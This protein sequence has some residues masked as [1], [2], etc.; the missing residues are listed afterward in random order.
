[1]V[2]G[3]SRP[4]YFLLS[5]HGL[6]ILDIKFSSFAPKTDSVLLGGLVHAISTFSDTI[7]DNISSESGTLNVIEREGKK[8][9][10]E[11]GQEVEAILVADQESMILMEKIRTILDIFE[12]NYLETLRKTHHI[13]HEDYL[14]FMNLTQKYLLA[15]LDENVVFRSAEKPPTFNLK[16]RIPQKWG[17]LYEFLDGKKSV[18]DVY[19]E[20]RWPKPYVLCRT[21][22]FQQLGIIKPVDISI[23]DTDLFI[24]DEAYLSGILLEQGTAYQS[25][26]KMWDE[27][28]VR[29]TQSLDGRNTIS[30]LAAKFGDTLEHERKVPHFLRWLSLQGYISPL[31]DSDLTIIIFEGFLNNLHRK[32]SAAVGDTVCYDM[33]EE[34]FRQDAS[35]ARRKGRTLSV[36]KLV[37]HDAVSFHFEKLKSIMKSRSEIITPLFQQAFLSFLDNI[38]RIISKVLGKK[39]ALQLIQLSILDTEKKYGPL[40]YDLLFTA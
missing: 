3:G 1:M 22:M 10:F 7:T 20:I 19:R 23:R 4:I 9:M 34:I 11:R 14:D 8:I 2:S 30:T 28:G 31:S 25:I 6:T 29:L 13:V 17:Q 18:N 32:L 33:F 38:I 35:Q 24:I 5:L 26:N 39:S 12:E 21:A 15:V 36:A 16:L 40:I 37:D 27:W